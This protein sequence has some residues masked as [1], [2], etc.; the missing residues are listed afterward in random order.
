V[1][2]SRK[3][4]TKTVYVKTELHENSIRLMVRAVNKIVGKL[5]IRAEKGLKAEKGHFVLIPA[6]H[7]DSNIPDRMG[8]RG[9]LKERLDIGITIFT[10]LLAVVVT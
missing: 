6:I 2:T 8:E 3:Q 9:S 5:T 4:V 7:R 10:L 1:T